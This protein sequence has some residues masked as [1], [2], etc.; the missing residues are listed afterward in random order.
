[1]VLPEDT[2]S[3]DFDICNSCLT[4]SLR[5][6]NSTF[7]LDKDSYYDVI[8]FDLHN[9]GKQKVQILKGHNFG[10]DYDLF[11]TDFYINIEKYDSSSGSYNPYLME[12]L[13]YL[14][15]NYDT[16]ISLAANNTYTYPI[17]IFSLYPIKEKGKYR[18]R[19]Y[20]RRKTLT[21]NYFLV[22]SKP[23]IIYIK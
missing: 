2:K 19:G 3:Q 15:H 9:C 10:Y 13:N 23:I 14:S 8:Y 17:N 22:I 4:L 7:F 1:M 11:D 6:P 16:T 5:S 12:I 20:Y 21:G 18:I